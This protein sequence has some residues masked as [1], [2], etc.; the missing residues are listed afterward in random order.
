VPNTGPPNKGRTA[1]ATA[2]VPTSG[3]EEHDG[4]DGAGAALAEVAERYFWL[5]EDSP[6]AKYTCDLDG[7]P[8]R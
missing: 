6:A 8:K 2:A 4:A 7:H 3:A 1:A 5:F